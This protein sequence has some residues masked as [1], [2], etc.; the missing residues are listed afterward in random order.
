MVKGE[1]PFATDV[2][3]SLIWTIALLAISSY[4]FLSREREFAV[5]I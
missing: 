3:Q 4:L 1:L 5:R 2:F